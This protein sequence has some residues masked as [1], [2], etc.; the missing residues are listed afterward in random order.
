MADNRQSQSTPT[1]GTTTAPQAATLTPIVRPG[2]ADEELPEENRRVLLVAAHPD[3]PEFSSAGTVANWVRSGIQVI[4]VLATSGDKGTPDKE[5]TGDRL[6]NQREDEQ[7]AAAAR[8]GV[9]EV[10]FLRFPD[11]ELTPSLELR[12]AV[13]KMIRLYKPYAVM[14]HDPL[15]LFYNNE[16]INHPDH[17][18]I[19]QATVDAIYPTARDPL[20]FNE[21]IREGLEPHKV[22]EIY[23]WGT[24]QP[25]VLVDISDTI[26]D[27]VE[28]LKLHVSQVGTATE[29]A[30][31]VKQ[32]AAQIAEPHGLAY[33]EAFRRV[34]MRM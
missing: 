34:V 11:G 8:I 30:E 1:A 3:D 15:T 28:A 19:G 29:L 17:R 4:F 10:V 23:L 25:N 26:E 33:A 9:T 31:R 22:K 12:G 7:R 16:F 20:Q 27:K 5:M 14:T 2:P 6:S 21:H 32:R 18:A 13:T 24:D